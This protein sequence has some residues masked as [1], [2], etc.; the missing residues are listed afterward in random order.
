[1]AKEFH[2]EPYSICLSICF[3]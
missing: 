3:I 1:M 2:F